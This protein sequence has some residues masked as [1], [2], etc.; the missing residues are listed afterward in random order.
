MNKDSKNTLVLGL[1][2]VIIITFIATGLIR[3]FL[4]WHYGMLADETLILIKSIVGGLAVTFVILLLLYKTAGSIS[5]YASHNFYF[6]SN[7]LK[8]SICSNCNR[9]LQK[10]ALIVRDYQM[11]FLLWKS[12]KYCLECG[13]GMI[14]TQIKHLNGLKKGIEDFDSRFPSA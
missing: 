7:V 10:G 4:N 6:D 2:G 1:L 13:K 14:D 12:N 5:H 9:P 3:S 11:S 8:N